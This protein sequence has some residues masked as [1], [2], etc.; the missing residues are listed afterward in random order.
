MYYSL[1]VMNINEYFD[2]IYDK[3]RRIDYFNTEVVIKNNIEIRDSGNYDKTKYNDEYITNSI[4]EIEKRRIY[5]KVFMPLYNAITN[6]DRESLLK[7]LY[8]DQKF[9]LEVFSDITGIKIKKAS[10]KKIKKVVEKYVVNSS[11]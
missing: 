4:N 6:K 2:K 1:T 5:N 8:Y 10:N 7:R 9:S 11:L 3:Y